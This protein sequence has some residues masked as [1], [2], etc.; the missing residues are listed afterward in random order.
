MM[1]IVQ[2]AT[3]LTGDSRLRSKDN[4][5]GL[6]SRLAHLAYRTLAEL[7]IAVTASAT[8]L[9]YHLLSGNLAG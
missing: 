1:G 8:V 6:A 2:T 7:T 5:S 9:I 4:S 3:F